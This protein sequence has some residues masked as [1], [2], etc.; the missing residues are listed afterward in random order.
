MLRSKGDQKCASQQKQRATK[1]ICF[2]EMGNASSW[3]QGKD[4][5]FL[6]RL[7]RIR[8]HQSLEE[9]MYP[10]QVTKIQTQI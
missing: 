4:S 2:Q 1:P 6:E 10:Q 7:L 9:I 8:K 3:H 5:G